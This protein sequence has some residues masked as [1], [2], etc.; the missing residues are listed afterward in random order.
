MSILVSTQVSIP[1]F[2]GSSPAWGS[3]LA[4]RSLLGVLYLPLSLSFPRSHSVSLKNEINKLKNKK[5]RK[6]AGLTQLL[7]LGTP[8]HAV[9]T[10]F[11]E[12]PLLFQWPMNATCPVPSTDTQDALDGLPSGS[13]FIE[14]QERI[15]ITNKELEAQN[16]M[17]GQG[18]HSGDTA[19]LSSH[20]G[21]P[22]QTSVPHTSCSL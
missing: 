19:K 1:R 5:E 3:A 10:P 4:V 17:S 20:L 2:V 8:V 22:L 6:R 16:F 12:G 7:C 14:T 21:R 11:P 13:P 18:N 15:P 9:T